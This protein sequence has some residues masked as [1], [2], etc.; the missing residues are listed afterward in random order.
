[1]E[2]SSPHSEKFDLS[3]SGLRMTSWRR[4]SLS[5]FCGAL[6]AVFVAAALAATLAMN[7]C[8]GAPFF[9]TTFFFCAMALSS[10]FGGFG[11]GILATILSFLVIDYLL[12]PPR[13]S[14]AFSF[15]QIPRVAAF[16]LA[17]WVV[18]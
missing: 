14:T 2:T 15:D 12:T 4:R 8:I 7:R 18:S 11:A 16:G 17:G 9:P 10:R 13:Y 6:S 5:L 1:M 3:P